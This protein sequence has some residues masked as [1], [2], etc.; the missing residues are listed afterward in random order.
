MRSRASFGARAAAAVAAV[1]SLIAPSLAAGQPPEEPAPVPHVKRAGERAFI[2]DERNSELLLRGIN[3]NAL[4]EYPDYFQQTVPLSEDDYA[5]M[6]ALGFNFLR[7]PI[8]W[9]LLAPNPGEISQ[10]YLDLIDANVTAAENAGLRVLVDFHQDR[11]NRNLRPGDEADGAPDWATLTE[12]E[13]CEEAFFTSPCSRAALDNFW[14]NTVVVGKGLQEHYLDAMLAVSRKLRDHDGM[15]GLEIMNEPTFGT[16]AP[17]AFE[18]QQLWPFERKMID[19]LRADGERRMIWF[20][21][22]LA[23]DVADT[24]IGQP[25]RL[26]EDPDLVYAPHI[27]TG[28][29]N[30]SGPQEL[31]ASYEAAVEEA[32]AYDAALVNAEWGNGNDPKAEAMREDHLDLADQH[33]MGSGFWMWKQREG[34][35]NWQ[36]VEEDGSIR[37]DSIRAQQLSRPHIDSIPGQILSTGYDGDTQVLSASKSGR[38]G[39]ATFWSGTVIQRGG[40]TALGK[41][42]VRAFVDGERVRPGRE[43]VT[44]SSATTGLLGY[45]I[46]VK[47]PK[48]R[49]SVE[50]RPGP[51]HPKL[52]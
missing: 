42:L 21:P 43:S 16:I 35:Y 27:Y 7:L 22:N 38:G 14:E 48:G 34:F 47:V 25:E 45:R 18:R 6:A 32:S 50:L 2:V 24:D 9:S 40:V 30:D 49:H 12:G 8:S 15:L 33:R 52:R 31:T 19:G 1:A 29:F 4:V 13:P 17:P 46:T 37:D 10:S 28:V 26:S 3:S 5:E 44:Y 39:K 20:G 11:Y 23:R 41:P 36:T 51:L